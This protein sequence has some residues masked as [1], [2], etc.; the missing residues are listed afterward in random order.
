MCQRC[1]TSGQYR[2][3][4][5]VPEGVPAAVR[6]PPLAGVLRARARARRARRHAPGLRQEPPLPARARRR[7]RP[8]RRH[9]TQHTPLLSS[10]LSSTPPLIL[11]LLSS[12]LRRVGP[13]P[14]VDT[15][16][17]EERSSTLLSF[18]QRYSLSC[19]TSLPLRDITLIRETVNY[20]VIFII[21]IFSF[22]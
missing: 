5:S 6:A 4:A 7:R 10:L 13:D 3:R 11:S 19:H 2:A 22:A 18:S 1:V 9:G 20:N 12:P 16:R 21:R 14:H 8:E 15:R 17:R